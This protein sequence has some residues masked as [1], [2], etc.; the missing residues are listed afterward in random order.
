MACFILGLAIFVA[1]RIIPRTPGTFYYDALYL[2]I[3]AI[4]IALWFPLLTKWKSYKT[5]LG[6]FVS[7]VSVLSYA[8]FLTNLLLLQILETSFPQFVS[9]YTIA[10]PV[11]WVLVFV[12]AYILYILVE[13]PFAKLRDRIKSV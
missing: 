9:R 1:T 10:Y 12:A 11:F 6:G 5:P 8:M 2:T 13:K 7:R 3:S 4:A